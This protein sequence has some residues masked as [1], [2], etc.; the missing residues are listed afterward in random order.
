MARGVVDSFLQRAGHHEPEAGE[1]DVLSPQ[2]TDE[3]PLVHDADPVGDEQRLLQLRRDVD[4]S[5]R[6]RREAARWRLGHRR[7][8]V[9]T[10]HDNQS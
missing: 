1:V 6:N 8:K 3:P 10:E 2:E 5:L 4:D 9:A 7:E